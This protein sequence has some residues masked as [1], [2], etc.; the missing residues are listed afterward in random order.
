MNWIRLSLLALTLVGCP[1]GN[2]SANDGSTGLKIR[3]PGIGVLRAQDH[4]VTSGD[5]LWP[6]STEGMPAR[7]LEIEFGNGS[8]TH[9]TRVAFENLDTPMG[10]SH[11]HKATGS[12]GPD[13]PGKSPL[14]GP[15]STVNG[16][17][18]ER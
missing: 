10:L 2:P 13:G 6:N 5:R 7:A 14:D 18:V 9:V 3:P 11:L 12:F 15:M 8:K 1:L 17:D 4:A 16:W